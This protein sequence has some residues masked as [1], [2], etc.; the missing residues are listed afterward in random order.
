ML[1]KMVSRDETRVNVY[2]FPVR[3]MILGKEG[4]KRPRLDSYYHFTILRRHYRWKLRP[5]SDPVITVPIQSKVWTCRVG[6]KMKP[7]GIVLC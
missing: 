6:Q 7:C 4:E 2:S 1:A 5:L 3:L